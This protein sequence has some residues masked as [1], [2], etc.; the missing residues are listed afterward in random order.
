MFRLS[1]P[2]FGLIR[3]SRPNF[4]M[5]WLPLK[6]FGVFRLSRQ[7]FGMFWLYRPKLGMCWLYRQNF[8]IF[9][10]CRSKFGI[11]HFSRPEIFKKLFFGTRFYK[12]RLSWPKMGLFQL[13]RLSRHTL[14]FIKL[15]I[16][17]RFVSGCV[18]NIEICKR[19][20]N[21][22]NHT[23]V[24]L[25][26]SSVYNQAFRRK[27]QVEKQLLKKT[28][29]W[30]KLPE[31]KRLVIFFDCAWPTLLM[32]LTCIS[33]VPDLCFDCVRPRLLF[34]RPKMGIFQL[35]SI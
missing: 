22:L 14:F 23:K 25:N 4:G 2:L 28:A 31:L 29:A 26:L 7:N 33:T 13:S 27:R 1:R 11:F 5:F 34:A 15:L 3:V 16:H 32:S 8:G 10:F 18:I 24:S 19:Y 35:F 9:Q 12:F 17:L 30:K 6:K 21:S 20:L